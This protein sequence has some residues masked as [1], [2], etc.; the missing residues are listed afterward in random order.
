MLTV[1]QFLA[2]YPQPVPDSEHERIQAAL[3]DAEIA[4][5]VEAGLSDDAPLP[6]ALEPI[7]LR[8]A[9]RTFANPLGISSE[10]IGDYTWRADNR[11]V[12]T[13]L[14]P[15][16]RA[17]IARVMGHGGVVSVPIRQHWTASD[18]SRLSAYGPPPPE[19][20]R[21]DEVPWWR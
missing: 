11:P 21:G 16:E 2:R 20:R 7:V 4:V 5:R 10:T 9:I 6:A 14:S 3:D 19:R 17:E 15:D 12:G 1:E 18:R 8:V 13:V